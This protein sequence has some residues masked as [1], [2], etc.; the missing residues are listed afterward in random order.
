MNSAIET[1]LTGSE[2]SQ[3]NIKTSATLIDRCPQD[4]LYGI[5]LPVP[6]LHAG[7]PPPCDHGEVRLVGGCDGSEGRV[8]VCVY[9]LWGTVCAS[10]W[11]NDEAE[12]V[13]DQLGRPYLG[14][15]LIIV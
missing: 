10:S 3:D 8:E 13:C 6:S 5:I 14:N 4:Q 9:G 12:V 7:T 11:G 15:S 2:H 1:L